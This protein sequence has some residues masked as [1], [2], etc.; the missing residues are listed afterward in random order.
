MLVFHETTGL[1]QIS[2]WSSQNTA[3]FQ[4]IL[5][6]AC[7]SEAFSA[8]RTIFVLCSSSLHVQSWIRSHW[9]KEVPVW[10]PAPTQSFTPFIFR[11]HGNHGF[12]YKPGNG[13]S[14]AETSSI[15]SLNCNRIE[16]Q[17]STPFH[18]AFTEPLCFQ[19]V[20]FPSFCCS[21]Q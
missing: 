13:R 14:M 2:P 5:L 10:S 4:Q 6:D 20:L 15:A 9:L 3:L 19:L 1:A 16:F 7:L 8:A 21:P 18:H 17:K 11:S 12:F